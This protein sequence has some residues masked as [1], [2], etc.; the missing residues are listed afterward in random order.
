MINLPPIDAYI[1]FTLLKTCNYFCIVHSNSMARNSA[2]IKYTSIM[3]YT[4]EINCTSIMISTPE[5]N[6][7]STMN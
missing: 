6:Y 4:S 3:I 2:E 7:T 5:I 1:I